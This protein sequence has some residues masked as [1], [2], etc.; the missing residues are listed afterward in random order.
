MTKLHR[1]E[2]LKEYIKSEEDTAEKPDEIKEG[3]STVMRTGRMKKRKT[4][5]RV[6]NM[7]DV[8]AKP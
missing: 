2:F 7:T 5:K 6:D 3:E 8:Q 1:P 4:Q